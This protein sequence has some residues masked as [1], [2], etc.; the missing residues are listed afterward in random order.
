MLIIPADRG[1]DWHRA[2]V[3]TATLILLCCI[4]Y[5]GWQQNDEQRWQAAVDYYSEHNLL[6]LEYPNFLSHLHQTGRESDAIEVEAAYQAGG[7]DY[8]IQWI[9]ADRSFTVAME[10]T[11]AAFWGNDVY[12]DWQAARHSVDELVNQI[13]IYK[14]GQIPAESRPITFL[15]ALF[16]HGD[17]MHLVGNMVILALTGAAVEAAIGSTYFLLCYLFCGIAG[18]LVY[19]LF[20]LH[21]YIP[22]IGASGAISGVMG[23]YVG[24]YRLRK[25]KFFYTTWFYFGYFTAP[26][27]I[28]LPVWIGWEVMQAF[29]GGNTGI[30]YMDHAG[31]LLA[32]GLLMLA[33]SK[34]LVQVDDSYLDQQPDEDADY[35]KALDD[36]L[37]QLASFN[38]ES[39]RRKLTTLEQL[40]P[41]R[42][43]VKEQRYYLEKLR[44]DGNPFHQYSHELLN[45]VTSDPAA[46][47]MLHEIYRDY[48]P[49]QGTHEL[50]A[51]TRLKLMHQFCQIDA[52]DTVKSMVKQAQEQGLQSPRLVKV[53]RL[54]ARN[55]RE[56]GDHQLGKRFS[57]MAETLEQ[58]L[59]GNQ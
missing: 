1:I 32:G 7:R 14:L 16:M 43:A 44:P 38:F 34:Y 22:S 10:K 28:M 4:V 3:M 19:T 57:Q 35:R 6:E 12:A 21:S 56:S 55:T 15:S 53:L 47:H 37:K 24:I 36:Y 45:L 9:L 50:A 39:A 51:E 2:P 30:A 26:A 40:Y 42:N 17:T 23:M 25:I 29:W 8:V 13:S 5:F 18:G 33:G 41:D 58:A 20:Q 52:W 54:L 31:G 49:L 48:L 27:L 11:N 59:A 46:I